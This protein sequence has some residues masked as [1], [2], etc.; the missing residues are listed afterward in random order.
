MNSTNIQ[1]T[2]IGSSDDAAESIILHTEFGI[3]SFT[4]GTE[5]ISGIFQE[6]SSVF[7]FIKLNQKIT[8][9]KA[10]NKLK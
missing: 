10:N 2:N 4:V 9:N 8:P 7:Q 1:K 5:I 3:N 6:I